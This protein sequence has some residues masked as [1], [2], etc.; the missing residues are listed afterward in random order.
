MNYKFNYE[1]IKSILFFVLLFALLYG[2]SNYYNGVDFDLWARL[3]QGKHVVQTGSVMYNDLVS[4]IPTHTWFDPEW[5]SS[6]IIYL[7]VN[8]MY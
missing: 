2:L 4:Y 7:I 3:I 1:K 8:A 5:L 6:A